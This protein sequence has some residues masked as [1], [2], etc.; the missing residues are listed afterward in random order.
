MTTDT[1]QDKLQAVALDPDG[2]ARRSITTHQIRADDTSDDSREITGIGVPYGET[3]QI[4]PGFFERFEAGAADDDG[5]ALA[6]W[7]H[8]DPMGLVVKSETVEAGR[9]V[10][11]KLSRTSVGDDAYTLVK[12]GVIRSLSI[13]FVM[14]DYRIEE[15][16][17]TGDITIIHTRVDV[18]EYSLVPWPAYASAAITDVRHRP[19]PHLERPNMS[20]TTDTITRDDLDNL[21]NA[22]TERT[23]DLSRQIAAL[24]I[25]DDHADEMLARA[26]EFTEIGDWI[27]AIVDERSARHE[28]ALE[29]HRDLTT[30]D[31]PSKIVNSPGFI[32][33]LTKQLVERRRWT[34]RFRQRALPNRGMSVDY[35]KTTSTAVVAEQL[36]ELEE[37]SKGAGFTVTPSSAPIRTFGGGETVS[38]QVIERSEAWVITQMFEAFARQYGR[39]TE[40]A[41]RLFAV[42]VIDRIIAAGEPDTVATIPADWSAFDWIDVLVDSAERFDDLGYTLDELALSSDVFKALAAEAGTD[43]RPLL[44]VSGTGSNVMGSLNLPKVSGNLLRLPVTVLPGT[45]SRG[46][47]YDPSAIET[48]ESPGAPFWLQEDRALNLARDYACYGYLAHIDPHPQAILPVVVGDSTGDGEEPAT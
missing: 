39:V 32:G 14:R 3:T 27:K 34:N 24:D 12:D 42:G 16:D 41:T 31:I 36:Q 4:A 38:R 10:T 45:T 23:E 20:G 28:T 13:G 30:S 2:L 43:G 22:F 1:L 11:L 6:L 46:M 37:L 7:Q 35:I 17:E 9:Q 47:F 18:R 48:L 29:L 40:T 25:G 33:D 8:C 21:S 15:D 5:D 44:E 19:N 26:A